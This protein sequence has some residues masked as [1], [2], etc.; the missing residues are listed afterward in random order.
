MSDKKPYTVT[1]TGTYFV[2]AE[3]END[4]VGNVSEALLRLSEVDINIPDTETHWAQATIIDGHYTT[5]DY[6]E[7]GISDYD[8]RIAE[9]KT[10]TE[11]ETMVYPTIILD[12][13]NPEIGDC[14]V[15][16]ALKDLFIRIRLRDGQEWDY[17][18]V[19][20]YSDGVLWF[21]ANGEVDEPSYQ[22]MVPITSVETITYT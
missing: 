21:I 6:D 20:D 14:A 19:T 1:M 12:E 7:C 10:I 5:I 16:H 2:F 18:E 15:L 4:A 3:S 17:V 9:L 8:K 13:S 11:S 22:V